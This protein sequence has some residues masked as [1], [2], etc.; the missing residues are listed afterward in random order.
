MKNKQRL[1]G[2]FSLAEAL[3]T[4]LIISIITIASIPI[5]TKKKRTFDGHGKW[6]CTLNAAGQHIMWTNGA[7]G[8]ANNPATWA[9]TGANYCKFNAPKSARNFAITAT[10]GGGGGAGADST[11]KS[12]LNTD[13]A[14]TTPGVYYMIAVGGGGGGGGSSDRD[15]TARSG[16]MGGIGSMSIY[17]NDTVSQL[18]VIRGSGGDRG[19]GSNDGHAGNASGSSVSVVKKN[20]TT[21]NYENC[22]LINAPG[23]MGGYNGEHGRDH[24]E[25]GGQAGKATVSYCG[26]WTSDYKSVSYTPNIE[27]EPMRGKFLKDKSSASDRIQCIGRPTSA[28]QRQVNNI[29]KIK[30]FYPEIDM[31][32]TTTFDRNTSYSSLSAYSQKRRSDFCAIPGL[33]GG[34]KLT[35]D[36]CSTKG[37]G[38]NDGSYGKDGYVGVYTKYYKSG[39]GGQAGETV[40]N[41]F[42]PSFEKTLVVTVGRGGKGGNKSAGQQGGTTIISNTTIQPLVGGLGGQ[43]K[44]EPSEMS[45]YTKTPGENGEKTKLYYSKEPLVGYGGLTDYNYSVNGRTGTGYGSGG[46]G[47]GISPETENNPGVGGDG[48]PGFVT[49][50]W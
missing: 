10:A 47:G 29:L 16:G 40:K 39:K 42:F 17:L 38:K 33:G 32:N 14:I 1:F 20:N 45:A 49:I 31:N 44:T 22:V 12:W 35:R 11:F 50:E 21:G 19:T 5:I 18:K 36:A 2:G 26:L 25:R 7:K 6:M 24:A 28:M 41:A 13:V 8:Q 27:T 23:G 48:M 37:R 43:M 15:N 46:G 3:I 34:A 4:L 30:K 9:T